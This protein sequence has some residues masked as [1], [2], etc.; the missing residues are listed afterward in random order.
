MA[1]AFLGS[2][3][4]SASS[5]LAAKQLHHP[6]L[7]LCIQAHISFSAPDFPP[8]LLQES[9]GFQRPA[10]TT[11]DKGSISRSVIDDI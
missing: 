11:Q 7:D 8:F 2:W 1:P 6:D 9:L 5:K 4:L 10:Q 3:P